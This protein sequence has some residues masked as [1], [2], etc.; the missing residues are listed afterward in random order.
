MQRW[1]RTPTL[2]GVGGTAEPTRAGPRHSAPY[3]GASTFRINMASTTASGPSIHYPTT[4]K[5]RRSW[6]TPDSMYLSAGIYPITI[7]SNNLIRDMHIHAITLPLIG[8]MLHC[9]RQHTL[10]KYLWT[11]TQAVNTST[12]IQG[13]GLRTSNAPTTILTRWD[14]MKLGRAPYPLIWTTMGPR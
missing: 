6:R 10:C 4:I 11:G 3:S 5:A 8:W 1:F 2:S 12:S 13:R 9:K 7:H 14:K